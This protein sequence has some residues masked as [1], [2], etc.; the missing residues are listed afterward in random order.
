MREY[1]ILWDFPD[2]KGSA[3]CV[4]HNR[5]QAALRAMRVEGWDRIEL[6]DLES[7]TSTRIEAR[8]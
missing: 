7:G 2:S 5:L 4:A 3:V 1:W 8:P 6:F